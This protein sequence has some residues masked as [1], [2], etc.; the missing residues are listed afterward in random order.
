[1]LDN[2]VTIY[3]NVVAKGVVDMDF[4]DRLRA[5]MEKHG[6]NNSS[7]AKKSGIPYTTID[8]LFKRGWEK[9][10][11][12]TIQKICGYYNVSLDYMV[13][14][15]EGLSDDAQLLAAKYDMLDESGMN[16]VKVVLESQVERVSKHGK[17]K[18]IPIKETAHDSDLYAQYNAKKELEEI[19]FLDNEVPYLD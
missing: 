6:D 16:L 19:R 11:V 9:A 14:G 15:T 1:M 17:L 8:G 2:Y 5:M 3:Y 13:Y 4:L 10:Q 18:K 12:S 7:L